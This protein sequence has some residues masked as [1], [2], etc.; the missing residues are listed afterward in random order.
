M[1]ES[2]RSLPLTITSPVD[3]LSLGSEDTMDTGYSSR[4]PVV[5]VPSEITERT[6]FS[7]ASMQLDEFILEEADTGKQS[8]R[9][10][11]QNLNLLEELD[12]TVK[13]AIVGDDGVHKPLLLHAFAKEDI[14]GD[15]IR[16]IF[17]TYLATL[18]IGG[19]R[20]SPV[21]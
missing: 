8:V 16:A 12:E 20:V 17:D 2:G 6:L 3:A 21:S 7:R 18:K 4:L 9:E 11:K 5:T 19:K 13:V 10:L 1:S 15:Q 14:N